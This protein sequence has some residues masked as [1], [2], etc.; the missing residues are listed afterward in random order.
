MFIIEVIPIAKTV[1][2]KTLSYFTDQDIPLGSIVNIPL[3]KK[4]IKGIVISKK[5]AIDMKS[6]IK[7]SPFVL[8][9]LI[10]IKS[11]RFLHFIS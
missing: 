3:R 4:I 7:K 2:V 9:K 10:D 11:N 5:S 1:G 8:K 6:E